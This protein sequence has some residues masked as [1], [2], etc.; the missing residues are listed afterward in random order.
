MK[1]LRMPNSHQS[2]PVL[3]SFMESLYL[4][5]SPVYIKACQYS[6]ALFGFVQADELISVVNERLSKKKGVYTY[7]PNLAFT[8][9]RNYFL[10]LYKSKAYRIYRSMN[11]NEDSDDSNA[12]ASS[13]SFVEVSMAPKYCIQESS[14]DTKIFV[15]ELIQYLS[16]K[17][18]DSEMLIFHLRFIDCLSFQKI[19]KEY[20][21]FTLYA[22]RNVALKVKELALDFAKDSPLNLI[23]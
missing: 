11:V 8:I 4:K 7:T 3:N 21:S 6:D 2:T 23:Y 15:R 1:V 10:D 17:L 13:L 18:S 16:S 9:L 20:P 22:I 14:L 5:S 12:S 19:R